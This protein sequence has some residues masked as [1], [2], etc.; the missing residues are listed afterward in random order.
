[1]RYEVP[2]RCTCGKK[3]I[4]FYVIIDEAKREIN[5][6]YKRG[7]DIVGTASLNDIIIQILKSRVYIK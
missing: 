3:K 4:I 7:E 2:I 6:A 5:V 1:M